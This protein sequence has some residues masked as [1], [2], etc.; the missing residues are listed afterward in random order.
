MKLYNTLTR[1]E[2]TFEPGDGKTVRMYVCGPTVYDHLHIGN[3]RPVIVFDALR[4]YMEQ[5]KGWEVIY[6]QNVT[7]VDEKLIEPAAQAGVGMEVLAEQYTNAYF[8]L[9]RRLGVE[10]P[11][12]SPRASEHMEEMIDLIKTLVKKGVAYERGG[13]VYFRVDAFK[14]YGKLSAGRTYLEV[15]VGRREPGLAHRMCR[16]VT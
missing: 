16:P 1:K 11:T 7:D 4:K 12:H 15:P 13:D 6:I 3:L 8:D 5:Y 14:D 9:M 2:E 10:E